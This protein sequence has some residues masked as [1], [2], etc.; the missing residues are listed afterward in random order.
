MIWIIISVLFTIYVLS[1]VRIIKDNTKGVI[2]TLGRI[3][4]VT[5]PGIG[6]ILPLFEKIY[7]VETK[8]KTQDLSDEML[9]TS[10][11]DEFKVKISVTYFVEHADRALK[12]EDLD[13]TVKNISSAIIRSGVGRFDTNSFISKRE[14]VLIDVLKSLNSDLLVYGAKVNSINIYEL[15]PARKL[16]SKKKESLKVKE[17]KETKPVKAEKI[18]KK[19]DKPL[20]KKVE[21]E[22]DFLLN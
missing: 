17:K 7:V 20:I 15:K 16:S 18:S 2:W 13:V 21:D 3:T 9:I 14:E 12:V 4:R 6:W 1:G 10:D 5:S 8:I 19:G 22:D 11:L